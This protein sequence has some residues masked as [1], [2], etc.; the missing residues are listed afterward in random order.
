[1][2]WLR[3]IKGQAIS[4]E[5]SVQCNLYVEIRSEVYAILHILDDH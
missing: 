2:V 4:E 5:D 3:K 1:M